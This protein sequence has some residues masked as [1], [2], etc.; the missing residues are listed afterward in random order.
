MKCYNCKCQVSSDFKYAFSTN[1]CPKC[2]DFLMPVEVKS[3]YVKIQ[4][5]LN[6]DN[7]DI[8]D[9]IVWFHSEFI[10]NKNENNSS[11]VN[12]ELE[13]KTEINE[14]IV[15]VGLDENLED[16]QVQEYAD[17]TLMFKKPKHSPKKI[18]TQKEQSL[19]SQERTN[20]FAKR[21]GLDK[22]DQNKNKYDNIIKD[23]QSSSDDSLNDDMG[24]SE[25]N[26][27]ETYEEFESPNSSP[28]SR[29]E[30]QSVANL[31]DTPEQSTDFNEIQKIQKLEQLAIT[32]SVGVI[33]RSE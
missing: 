11:Q 24:Y 15:E 21:A 31:F 16:I 12:E 6:K 13:A 26:S 14:T 33:R 2:G 28:L 23:I 32:G 1:C 20:L 18:Q 19:L 29:Q 5:F 4:D 3:L 9:L 10:A 7:N 27:D 8:G 25:Y 30:I 17:A 22:L